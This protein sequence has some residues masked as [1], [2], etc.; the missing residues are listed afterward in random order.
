MTATDIVTVSEASAYLRDPTDVT[1]LAA[2]VSAVSG[3]LDDLCGPVV[4]RAQTITRDGGNWSIL[5]PDPILTVT[6]LTEYASTTAQV[7]TVETNAS[8][9]A[10]G[11]LV[12]AENP[13]QVW[14]RSIGSAARFV[15]G[16]SNVVLVASIG[17]YANTAA[18]SAQFK[19]AALVCVSHL[20]QAE[21]GTRGNT[22][23]AFDDQGSS[24]YGPGWAI[25]RRALDILGTEVRPK[26]GIG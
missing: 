8:K 24:T 13:R 4:A 3:R 6:S 20:W 10:D 19:Q 21:H 11:Y 25:P 18:V 14:R 12:D 23:G 16:A 22:F 9:P 5:I 17:R 7:L 1:Q 15:S 2:W 26:F